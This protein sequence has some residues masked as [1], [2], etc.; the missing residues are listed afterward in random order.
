MNPRGG[1]GAAGGA[2]ANSKLTVTL[3]MGQ[4]SLL[5]AMQAEVRN[6][7]GDPA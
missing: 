6:A 5:K 7:G 3:N 2:G 4:G 1:Y